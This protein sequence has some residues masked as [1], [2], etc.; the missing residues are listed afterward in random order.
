MLSPWRK[1]S[2]TFSLLS[3]P[4]SLSLGVV[5]PCADARGVCL[6]LL[7]LPVCDH[8]SVFFFYFFITPIQPCLFRIC[9]CSCV[10]VSVAA[11]HSAHF[12][13]RQKQTMSGAKATT[14]TTST[15]TV[16]L[17]PCL[18]VGQQCVRTAT[19]ANASITQCPPECGRPPRIKCAHQFSFL[20]QPSSTLLLLLLVPFPDEGREPSN[21]PATNRTMKT[22]KRMP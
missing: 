1:T 18:I 13:I 2:I 21:K 3:G 17:G 11:K 12:V 19:S 4:L 9:V 8:F 5:W 15:K 16:R 10:S 6:Q 14:T 7:T 22:D 20:D